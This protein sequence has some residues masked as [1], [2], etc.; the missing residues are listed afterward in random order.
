[1]KEMEE[2]KAKGG[3]RRVEHFFFAACVVRYVC[4]CACVR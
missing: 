2:E 3:E 1:M 4:V